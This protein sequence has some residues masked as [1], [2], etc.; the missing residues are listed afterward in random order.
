MYSRLYRQILR[1]YRQ[2]LVINTSKVWLSTLCWIVCFPTL[3]FSESLTKF[4]FLGLILFLFYLLLASPKLRRK[5]VIILSIL[6]VIGIILI[7]DKAFMAEAT[8]FKR[9]C[10]NFYL[11]I[12]N[13]YSHA[14]YGNGH[15]SNAGNPKTIGHFGWKQCIIWHTTHQ[16][17]DWWCNQYWHVFHYRCSTA[18]KCRF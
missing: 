7:G 16:P 13:A 5:S 10:F 15:A 6:A 2:I 1:L 8:K 11:L 4:E 18:R 12:P 14:V 9:I 17:S 3:I